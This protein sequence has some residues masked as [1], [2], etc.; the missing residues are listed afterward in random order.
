M[1][2]ARGHVKGNVPSISYYTTM[3]RRINRLNIN[4]EYAILLKNPNMNIS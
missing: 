2:S 4:V 1:N 3:S